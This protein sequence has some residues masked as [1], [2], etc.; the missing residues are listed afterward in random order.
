MLFPWAKCPGEQATSLDRSLGSRERALLGMM[1]TLGRSFA[2]GPNHVTG[3][4]GEHPPMPNTDARGSLRLIACNS[5]NVLATLPDVRY[6][7]ILAVL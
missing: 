5:H 7:P 1:C 6:M 3:S 4:P 2:H